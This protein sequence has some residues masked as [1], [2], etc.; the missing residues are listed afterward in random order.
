MNPLHAIDN[1]APA[2]VILILLSIGLAGSSV[3]AWVGYQRQSLTRSGALGTI[4]VGTAIF[5]FGGPAWWLLLIAFFVSSSGLSHFRSGRKRA[6][7]D[8]F[9]KGARRDIWQ[10]LANGGPGALL[11]LIYGFQSWPWLGVAFA[12]ALATVNAD[13][14]ATELGILS[15]TPPRLITTGRP[16][17]AGTNGAL[18]LVGTVAALAGAGFIG[19]LAGG[20]SLFQ[21]T[22]PDALVLLSAAT[23]G[24]FGGAMFDSLLGATVQGVYL[25]DRCRQETEHRLHRCGHP[26]RPLRGWPW[27]DNDGVNFL[28]ALAG[29]G[30]AI[31]LWSL[32]A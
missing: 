17:E 3:I 18:S 24:G 12:G 8:K 4:G 1:L 23:L 13:T 25:C 22:P 15:R 30:M 11:S 2:I 32:L 28:S 7:T 10:V 29:M 6:L 21:S 20:F 26:T 9:S 5:T 14:W 27:L 19:G 16:V 31:G